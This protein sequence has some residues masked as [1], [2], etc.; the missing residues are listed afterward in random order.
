MRFFIPAI[1]VLALLTSACSLPPE[2]QAPVQPQPLEIPAAEPA[3]LAGASIPVAGTPIEQPKIPEIIPSESPTIA[4]LDNGFSPEDITVKAGSSITWA[5]NDN[6]KHIIACYQNSKRLFSSDLLKPGDEFSRE[7]QYRGEVSCID[8]I[9]GHRLKVTVSQNA[10]QELLSPT[11]YAVG[12]IEGGTEGGLIATIM[13][14]GIFIVAGFSRKRR[15][16]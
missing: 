15:K 6:K 16:R 4:I 13:L 5:V 9:Y 1:L 12:L 14:L 3:T 10:P 2:E 11:G 7:F 8:V